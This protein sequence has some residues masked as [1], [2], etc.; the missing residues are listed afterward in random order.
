MKDFGYDIS[1]YEGIGPL[2]G[3][4]QTFDRLLEA[5][6]SRGIRVIMDLVV[7]HTSDQH[8][9]FRAAASGRDGCRTPMQ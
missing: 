8:P 1:D 4:L 2:F 5:C 6:H 3:N 7:N 9:W